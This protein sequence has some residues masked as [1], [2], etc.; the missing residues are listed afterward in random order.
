MRPGYVIAALVVFAACVVVGIG[1]ATFK[2][3]SS[4][5]PAV[6][7]GAPTFVEHV[8]PP[9]FRE[10]SAA[11]GDLGPLTVSGN[12]LLGDMSGN[13]TTV[14]IG[15]GDTLTFR[16]LDVCEARNL[17]PAV[18][19]G[20]SVMHYDGCHWTCTTVLRAIQP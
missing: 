10:W 14:S 13:W 7:A 11:D 12:V 6:E 3:V 4:Y 5:E 2:L 18:D 8:E 19:C 15:N 1:G 17:M 20:D 16:D 9:L